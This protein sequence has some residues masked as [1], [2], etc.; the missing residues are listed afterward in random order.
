[1]REV[2]G[3]EGFTSVFRWVFLAKYFTR[4]PTIHN[5]YFSLLDK[6]R[7]G[8]TPQFF[9][10]F[11]ERLRGAV[12][13]SFPSRFPPR[14]GQQERPTL[15]RRRKEGQHGIEHTSQKIASLQW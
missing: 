13:Y 1:M 9:N 2:P 10:T 4:F 8:S 15:R 6:E 14:S 7:L 12:R 5:L 11:Y 3:R